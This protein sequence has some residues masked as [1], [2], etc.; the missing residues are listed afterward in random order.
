MLVC[1]EGAGEAGA[2]CACEGVPAAAGAWDDEV[3]FALGAGE[4]ADCAELE[5][6]LPAG[7]FCVEVLAAGGVCPDCADVEGAVE[8]DVE[9]D[10]GGVV[11]LGWVCA[12]GVVAE[13]GDVAGD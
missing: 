9:D 6:V 2:V 11:E 3:E 13:F 8:G 12:G 7:E 4:P 5:L 1:C 10:V